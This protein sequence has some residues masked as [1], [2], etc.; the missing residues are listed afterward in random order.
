MSNS[1]KVESMI[2]RYGITAKL[3]CRISRGYPLPTFEWLY[4]RWPCADNGIDSNCR[5]QAD[6]W[7]PLPSAIRPRPPVNQQSLLSRIT[8]PANEPP[9]MAAYYM[10][11]AKN[12]LGEDSVVYEFHRYSKCT[13][14]KNTP[15]KSK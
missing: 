7:R 10:C 2:K 5:P 6:K 11:K 13:T 15:Y 12:E 14:D 4:Q 3:E 9:S 8:L 1:Q